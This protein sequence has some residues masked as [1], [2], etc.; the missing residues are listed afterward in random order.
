VSRWRVTRPMVLA[1]CVLSWNDGHATRALLN[2]LRVERTLARFRGVRLLVVSYDNGSTDDTAVQLARGAGVID[3]AIVGTANI[4]SSLPRN[5]MIDWS[6]HAN[7]DA[8][9]LL[10]GDIIPI[11][12]C[13]SLFA[14]ELM[15]LSGAVG[16]VGA[17]YYSWAQTTQRSHC[18]PL[19]FRVQRRR[20]KVVNSIGLTQFGVFKAEMFRAGVRFEEREPFNGPGWG[21]EDND[22]G[23]QMF[24]HGY[25][26][27]MY[28]GVVYRHLRAGGSIREMAKA[29]L[30]PKVIYEQRRQFVADKWLGHQAIQH[31]AINDVG[32][33]T[34]PVHKLADPVS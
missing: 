26:T 31:N 32:F 4:G 17:D 16:S 3:H 25:A 14:K 5:E 18:T 11:P 28:T 8:I 24:A 15:S 1:V 22:L 21:S 20:L 2:S 23:F 6:L 13:L 33:A 19:M 10:D 9:A 30:D 27:M 29:G 12:G 34:F 7:A